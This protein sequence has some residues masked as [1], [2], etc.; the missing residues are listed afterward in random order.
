MPEIPG[1]NSV[2]GTGIPPGRQPARTGLNATG[3]AA[4]A[5]GPNGPGDDASAAR[6]QPAGK[7]FFGFHTDASI[8]AR[9][10][11][12]GVTPT[13]GNLRIAQQLLRYGQGLD[14]DAIQQVAQAWSQLGHGDAQRLEAIVALQAR[15]LA[16]T[17]PNVQVMTQLLAGGPITHLLARLTM[18][19]KAEQSPKL[20][21]IGQR[22]NGLWQLGH[23]DKDLVAQL[24][25]FSRLLGELREEVARFG[26]AD[27]SP[28][29]GAELGRFKDL[30]DAH[31][32]LAQQQPGTVYTPFFIWQQQQ[33]LPAELQV[34]EEG[35]GTAGVGSF[36]KVTLAVETLTLGRVVV[37]F[38]A[39]RDALTLRLDVADE[40]IKKR[41]DPR[42]VTLRQRLSGRGYLVDQLTCRPDGAGR[43]LS[44]LLP[45][46]RDLKKLSR[47][48]GV[49]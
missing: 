11:A 35:G 47:A 15:G 34:Q 29:L 46:R 30:M 5:A 25:D 20:G 26:P 1:N 36:L 40:K 39:V 32:L 41:M 45:V 42:L 49:L 37:E 21:G 33:P 13:L 44:T 4:G 10:A 8:M 9:L 18:A 22:L 17:G 27:L 7:R 12:M 23:A 2:P 16:V 28:E 48:Q 38:V 24:K 3:G 14:P 19:V 6:Q 43:A 31:Q